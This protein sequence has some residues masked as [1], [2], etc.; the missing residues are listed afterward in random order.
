MDRIYIPT[1]RR[2]DNQVTFNNLPD[3]YKE[4]T[5]MVV[6]EQERS[7][8]KY[9]VEYLV[10]GDNIGIA[11]TRKEIIYHAGDSV[12]CMYDD[13]VRFYRRNFKYFGRKESDMEGSKRLMT[14]ED[15]DDMYGLFH[16]WIDNENII[17][18]GNRNAFLPPSGHL[19]ADLA[20]IT[21]AFMI[22]GKELIKFRDEIDW[23]FVKVGEDSMMTLEFLLRGYKNRRSDLF[24]IDQNF[25]GEGGCSE[26]R[27][28]DFHYKEHLKLMKKYPEYVYVKRNVVRKNI[29]MIADFKYKWKD[30]YNSSQTATILPFYR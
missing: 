5:I 23:T 15:F 11:A 6:Q 12:F 20:D 21:G 24:V 8:Y 4:K 16:T 29:G 1:F 25:W 28:S 18:I 3:K 2:A 10:V 30:A 14:E 7:Q 26:F 17:Q 22:N 13:D 27:D 9:D 19:Q